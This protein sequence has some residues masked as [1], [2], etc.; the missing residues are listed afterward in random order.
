[1]SIIFPIVALIATVGSAVTMAIGFPSLRFPRIKAA[2]IPKKLCVRKRTACSP[3]EVA[4]MSRDNLM[5][6][7]DQIII[8]IMLG[9]MQLHLVHH[10]QGLHARM[11]NGPY[12]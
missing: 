8:E 11:G 12:K 9:L 5:K 6:V 7:T 2:L 1:M 4:N 10:S 3:E